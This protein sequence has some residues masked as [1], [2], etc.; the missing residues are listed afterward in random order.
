MV[1]REHFLY[2]FSFPKENRLL[3]RDAFLRLASSG[4]RLQ[5]NHFIAAICPGLNGRTRLGITATKKVGSAIKRNRIKRIIREYFRLNRHGIAGI[6]D[7]NIIAKKTVTGPSPNRVR[8][9][10]KDIFDRISSGYAV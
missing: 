6:W 2:S 4:K 1:V 10:L 3:K 8:K 9:S 7:I 5:N